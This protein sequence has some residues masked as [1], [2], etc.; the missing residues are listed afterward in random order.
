MDGGMY[1]SEEFVRRSTDEKGAALDIRTMQNMQTNVNAQLLA[2]FAPYE[3]LLAVN[4]NEENQK[5]AGWA[6]MPVRAF[7]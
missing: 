6:A 2:K 4:V 5:E 7:G 1:N 3:A